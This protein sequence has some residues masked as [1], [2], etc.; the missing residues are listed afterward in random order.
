MKLIVVFTAV[1]LAFVSAITAETTTIQKNEY[2]KVSDSASIQT[3]AAF[4][5]I[6]TV[7]TEFIMNGKTVSTVT[8]VDEREAMMRERITRTTVS[9]GKLSQKIQL[10]VG[11]RQ[12]Y[13]SDDGTSWR[14]SEFECFG[15]VNFYAPYEPDS[16]KYSVR[17]ETVDG[18]PVNVYREYSIFSPSKKTEKKNFRER[19]STI[20]GNGHYISVADTEGTLNPRIVSLRRIQSWDFKT[21]L[22]AIEPPLN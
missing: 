1:L 2:D 5:F 14:R 7:I 10:R 19:L 6:F 11:F 18:N 9:D 4:P 15:P 17:D 20:D 22:K 12:N 8:E 13:C 3:N 21:R 16:V